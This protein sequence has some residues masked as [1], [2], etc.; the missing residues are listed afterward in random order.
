MGKFQ[1]KLLKQVGDAGNKKI[2]PSAN[3]LI[4]R[5]E[6]KLRIVIKE[7]SNTLQKANYFIKI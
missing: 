2:I 4:N 6:I 1:I 7:S 3:G 5:M